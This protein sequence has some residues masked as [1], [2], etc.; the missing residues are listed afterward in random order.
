VTAHKL[1]VTFWGKE[2]KKSRAAQTINAKIRVNGKY[3]YRVTIKEIDTFPVIII[4]IIIINEIIK[5][6]VKI[7]TWFCSTCF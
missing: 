3:I 6:L 2:K 1:G 7:L 4:I 5:D